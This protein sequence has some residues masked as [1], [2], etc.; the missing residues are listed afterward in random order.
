MSKKVGVL[1]SSG[2]DST[3]LVYKNLKKGNTVY[4]IYIEIE[5]N[6]NK[7]KLEKN[8]IELL[9]KEFAKEFPDKIRYIN[10]VMKTNV[11]ASEDSIYLKQ[12]PVWIMGLLFS[13]GIG[14]DEIQIGYVCGDDSASY[15]NDMKDIYYSYEKISKKLIPIKF[16]LLKTKKWEIIRELPEKYHKYIYSCEYPNIVDGSEKDE[17]IKYNACCDCTAC[18]TIII[19]DYYET[20][21]FPEEYQKGLKRFFN[22]KV[23]KLGFKMVDEITNE[24]YDPYDYKVE[25]AI[26]REGVQLEL[27]FPRELPHGFIDTPDYKKAQALTFTEYNLPAKS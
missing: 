15:A 11:G 5:N 20:G 12:V 1:F 25:P 13:Q 26:P 18:K 9:Y 22:N 27:E 24:Q 3:Y 2:L 4:P 23:R 10:Y 16:P 21:N 6:A 14:V 19:S 17:L 7:V 8:R